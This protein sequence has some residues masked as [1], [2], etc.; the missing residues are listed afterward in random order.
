[1]S[2]GGAAHRR[3][4]EKVE[5][6][7]RER[8]ARLLCIRTTPTRRISGG[9]DGTFSV[10]SLCRFLIL[11]RCELL[12]WVLAAACGCAGLDDRI[13][14]EPVFGPEAPGPYRHPASITELAN[15]DLYLAYY[16]GSGEYA[17]DTA[18]YGSRK[19][20]GQARWTAPEVI[21]DTPRGQAGNPVVWQAPDGIVWLFHVVRGGETWSRSRIRA[22]TSRDGARTWSPSFVLAE[23][24]GMMVRAHPIVL[25]DGDYLLPVY[26]ETGNDREEVGADTTSLFLRRDAKTGR[27]TE[28]NRIRSRL[29][30]LQPAV[31]RITDDYLVCYCRR[32][33]GYEPRTD[34]WL[35]RSESRD[36]GWTW[37]EGRDSEFPNPNAAADFIRLRNGHL[38]LVFNDSM[39]ERTPLTAALSVDGDR[40]Y[41]F[42]RNIAE[43]PD[44]FAYPSA[45][46]TRDGTIHVVFTS[47][48]RTVIHH[49]TFREGAIR[50][51]P[52]STSGCL[53][54]AA[55][56]R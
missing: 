36:G 53:P 22:R 27:W 18:V 39:S 9:P 10:F 33:G 25:A 42:R 20:T 3:K 40:T 51:R 46:Q 7:K 26:H 49:A 44:S 32:G 23:E 19:A 6:R 1:M 29:G 11:H 38:L 48:E 12:A 5:K 52:S 17:D 24:E 54:E 2:L 47:N 55:A 50:R 30:N 35:V 28:T 15:G 14:I 21:S 13:L 43:G 8:E 56:T 41:P 31:A 37:T 4:S 34:G 45:I 16:G